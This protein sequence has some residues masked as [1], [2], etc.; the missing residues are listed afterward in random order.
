MVELD[1][2]YIFQSSINSWDIGDTIIII[3]VLLSAI[4]LIN[5]FSGKTRKYFIFITCIL[6]YIP[7]SSKYNYY[8]NNKDVSSA[9]KN[10]TYKQVEGNIKNLYAMQTSGH[11][12]EKFDV[13]GVHFEIVYTGDYPN[14][15]TLFYT[16]TKNR[17]GP[18]Q[19]NGQRVKIYYIEDELTTICIPFTGR[20]IT[21]NENQKN[22]IIKMWVYKE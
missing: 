19:K 21:F 16:L 6:I 12:T 3:I 22:Q 17:D 18:I 15:K 20:C 4:V 1:T 2:R 8:K 13:N 5:D 10:R 14:T 9:F 11:E 7:I